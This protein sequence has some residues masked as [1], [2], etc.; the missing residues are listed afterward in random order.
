MPKYQI[1]D[2]RTGEPISI[3]FTGSDEFTNIIEAKAPIY[4]FKLAGIPKEERK[5]L[6]VQMAQ[7]N[8][9]VV[10]AKLGWGLEYID[11]PAIP[12]EARKVKYGN[13]SYF[14]LIRNR[15]DKE[16]DGRLEVFERPETIKATPQKLRRVFE[17]KKLIDK[18]MRPKSEKWE[19]MR[20]GLMGLL[21]VLCLVFIYLLYGSATGN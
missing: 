12:D 11:P 8:C 21:I 1:I 13:R 2:R 7:S 10:D 3:K 6:I 4:V 19:K 15:D 9:L 16:H 5:D 18:A 17:V 14:L 20:L